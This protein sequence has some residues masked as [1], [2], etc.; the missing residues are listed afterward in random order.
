L[1][2]Y[3]DNAYAGHNITWQLSHRIPFNLEKQIN[4]LRSP[5]NPRAKAPSGTTET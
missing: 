3:V 1:P 5:R 2:V 4:I